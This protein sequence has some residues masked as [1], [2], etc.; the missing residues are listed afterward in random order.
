MVF[1][2][3]TSIMACTHTAQEERASAVYR[4]RYIRCSDPRSPNHH[5]PATTRRKPVVYMRA[6][7]QISRW[8]ARAR[9]HGDLTRWFTMQCC[10]TINIIDVPQILSKK[11]GASRCKQMPRQKRNNKARNS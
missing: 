2:N 5:R 7:H 10:A 8:A 11:L 6:R 9:N 3:V 4:A 1:I